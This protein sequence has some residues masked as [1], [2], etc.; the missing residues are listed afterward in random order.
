MLLQL[1]GKH[2]KK[3]EKSVMSRKKKN[4]PRLFLSL[5]SDLSFLFFFFFFQM[6]L[7]ELLDYLFSSILL[8]DTTVGAGKGVNLSAASYLIGL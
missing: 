7:G 8:S 5:S 3:K 1:L 4:S 2:G 6:M